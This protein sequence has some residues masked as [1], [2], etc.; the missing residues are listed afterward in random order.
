MAA[1][2]LKLQV[3]TGKKKGVK[4]NITPFYFY[5]D[6]YTIVLLYLL[7]ST[8]QPT[9]LRLYHQKIF[10]LFSLQ[11]RLHHPYDPSLL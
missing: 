2:I 10:L 7:I 1:K 8:K 5:N 9:P 11:L 4:K 3:V 6:H